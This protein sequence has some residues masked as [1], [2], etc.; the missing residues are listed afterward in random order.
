MAG[1]IKRGKTYSLRMRVP[2]RYASV[3]PRKF[4][5]R[6]LKTGDEREAKARSAVVE[7]QILSEL[8]ARLAGRETP[9]S[10]SHFE[11]IAALATAR[12]YSYKTADELAQGDVREALARIEGLIASGDQPGSAA[13][14]AILGAVDRPRVT[15]TE[16]AESMAD[17]FPLEVRDKHQ[18]QK[19]V[20]R[21]RWERPAAKVVKMM[22]ID[23][24]LEDISRAD[25]ISLR[26]ALLDRVTEG[27]MRGA[28]AQKELQLLNLI[29]TKYFQSLGVDELDMPPSPFRG[30]GDGLRRL[31]EEGRKNEVP[32]E[33]IEA[34]VE[35]ETMSHMNEE[36]R[37][38]ILV[39][40]ET[41]CRQAEITDISPENIRLDDDIPHL[42]LRRQTGE[43]ARELKNKASARDVPLVG[44]ALDAM[45]RH[46]SGFPRYRA[47]GTF[48]A[49]ANKSLRETGSLPDG[50]TIGGLRHSFET[51]LKKARVD[52]DDRGEL[53]GHSVKRIRGREHYGD[54]MPLAERLKYHKKIAF[55]V[56]KP[57]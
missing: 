39:I 17:R 53:M 52:T 47:K 13:S 22:G 50:V 56:P 33:S 36:L 40:V 6:T 43:Y 31:D 41:G 26:D 4:L 30:L 1:L 10:H 34:L 46:A 37:D 49:A 11:A 21:A 25:A 9:G 3:E 44:V 55:D 8:D 19:K 16:V 23:P 48:S 7:R 38:I 51:R 32:I 28:S 42:R 14:K 20:W 5:F 2:V 12:G 57:R 18:K 15:L 54:A 35:P 27:D 45:R 24:I 29:W